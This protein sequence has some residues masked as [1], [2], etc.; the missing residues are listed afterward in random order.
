[1]DAPRRTWFDERGLVVDGK[2]LAFYAGA[3]PYWQLDPSSWTKALRALH[4]RGLTIVET[5]VPWRLHEPAA[6][7]FD[8]SG[9]LDLPRFLAEAQAAGL[10]VVLRVGPRAATTMT[11]A[12]FPDHVLA[13]PACL[14]RTSHGSPAW[15]PS[16][17]RAWP[18]P[19]YPSSA[20][21]HHV[22]RWY[23]EL[24]RVIAADGPVVALGVDTNAQLFF[25]TGAFDLDYHPDA[26]AW[27][28]EAS[29]LDGAPPRAWDPDDAQR[30]ISWVRFKDQ[31]LA[32]ALGVFAKALD[33][34]GL[35][36]IA[37]FHDLPGGHH[38]LVDPRAIQHAIGGPV[39]VDA[40]TPGDDL[41][42]LRRRALALTGTAAPLP[43]AFDVGTGF[44][45]WVPSLHANERDQLLAFL[46]AG[47]RG[48][49]VGALDDRWITQLTSALAD[50]E[51]PTLRRT[52]PGAL[53]ASAADDRWG[54]ATNVIDPVTPVLAEALDLGPGG[55][56][57]L[58]TDA[59]A[60][61]QRRWQ[62]AI[63][64]ALELAQVPYVI[65]D[66]AATED[67]LARY[68]AVIVPTTSRIDRG[69]WQRIR[70]LAEHKRAIVVIGP[71]TPTH[72]E[73]GHP[74]HEAPPK[75]LGRVREASLDDLPGLAED[76]AAIAGELPEAWS[77]LHGQGVRSFH[78]ATP[79]GI[80]RAVFI[81][82]DGDKAAT[83]VLLADSIT[84]SLRDPFT[85]ELVVVD[86]GKLTVTVPPRSIRMLVV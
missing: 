20:F 59:G 19:S 86:N 85:S 24:A 56:A 82:N 52:T 42:E 72:D 75:R 81:A 22:A 41:R 61:T 4:A 76:L 66:D 6:G 71:T 79:A 21:H 54:V 40:F 47:A 32:R 84:G 78:H 36:G 48:F 64:T 7:T 45:P 16:P 18:L 38:G 3:L 12:G 50:I 11:S 30:G 73:Y 2:H 28:R 44:F 80:T 68:H 1:M 5:F 14:A 74:L 8:W 33:D 70:G 35:G 46:A 55:A 83:A 37:R 57:E 17:P 65:V 15:L 49:H 69:L 31:Y 62:T 25:R 9:R 60:V 43:I 23:G 34:A 27:W 58:G 10:A 29:G 39:A 77:V 26:I 53:V 51:W 13:D 63:T 67:E